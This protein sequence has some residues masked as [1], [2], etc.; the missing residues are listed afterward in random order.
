MIFRAEPIL[1]ERPWGGNRLKKLFPETDYVGSPVGEAWLLSGHP[2]HVSSLVHLESEQ[3]TTLDV[4]IRKE[5]HELFGKS[6]TLTRSGLFP[7]LLKLIDAE[8]TLSVQLHPSDAQA[9]ALG[10]KDGGKTEMWYVLD[11]KPHSLIYS[12]IKPDISTEK[13]LQ[14][15]EHDPARIPECL[16]TYS[17]HPHD[18]FFIPAGTLHAIGGG[19][20][21][22][23]IQQTSDV[24][25]RIYDW[26]RVDAA[27]RPRPLHL[28]QAAHVLRTARDEITGLG[29]HRSGAR[30]SEKDSVQTLVSCPYFIAEILHIADNFPL[31]LPHP[32]FQI[33]LPIE[34]E[35]T[36]VTH[37]GAF[38]LPLYHAVLLGACVTDARVSGRG[39][40]Q[41]FYLPC[42]A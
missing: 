37:A 36:L 35:T 2:H 1:V 34:G 14:I 23:E 42:N 25:Y 12:G 9:A 26:D 38:P 28:K 5:P 6:P 27:G 41:R 4:L 18:V 16:L 32:S 3:R 22:S 11:A 30:H 8:E 13:V 19:I 39:C 40:L 31:T 17:A 21:L 10:E 7:L 29:K 24:T 33:L 20:L 15:L